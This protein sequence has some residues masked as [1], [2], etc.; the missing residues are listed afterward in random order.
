MKNFFPYLAAIASGLLLAMCYPGFEVASGLVWVWP[1]PLMAALWL[2]GG[3]SKRK[4][5][6]W[7]VG[8]VAGLVFWLINV[9]WLLAM[10]EL[11]T[12]PMVGALA[13]WLM[14]SIYLT[15]YFAIWGVFAATVGNPW[16]KKKARVLSVIEQKMAEKQE[17]AEQPKKRRITGF[18]ASMRVMRFAIMHASLWVV[19]EWLRGWVMTGFGWNGLGVAFHEVPVMMQVADIVGVSGVAFFPML[20][21]SVMLQTGKRFFDEVRAGKFQAHFEIG[22][23]MGIV[24]AVFAYGINRMAY[25]TNQPSH[26]VKVLILQENIPQTLKWDERLE[27]QH[28]IGYAE[29]LR[30]ELGEIAAANQSKMES[31]M[32][33]GEVVQLDYPDLLILPESGLTEPML[34]TGEIEEIYFLP[35][36][37]DFLEDQVF[38]EN[39]FKVIFGSTLVEGVWTEDGLTYHPEG[40]AFNA[41]AVAEPSE[42]QQAESRIRRVLTHGKNHLVPFG[43]YLPNIPFLAETAELFS[44]TSYAKNFSKGGSFDPLTVELQGEQIQLIPTVCFEDSVGRLTRKFA[45][46]KPQM[47]VNITNDGWFGESEAA[48]QHMANAKFRS[49]E[50][51]RPMARAANTGVSGV[52]SVI[53]SLNDS[54]SGARN[55]IGTAENPFI[56]GGLFTTVKVPRNGVMTIYA[57]FGDWF[58]ACC[59]LLLLGF[60]V[61][62]R[63][64]P[65]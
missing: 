15:F 43:E 48:L 10:G 60:A 33:S 9:K 50:L 11:D 54:G 2:G 13:G 28:Y 51:R 17:S 14:L 41:F 55:A 37:R 45:R 8:G 46:T 4:R 21:A 52:V 65:R 5:F 25:H 38:A 53:G 34:Y 31:A 30:T 35:L 26:D 59:L 56:K 63:Y 49:V 29:S 12:V 16:R 44:G 3:E 32:D 20:L 42:D 62:P 58:V 22:L 6:G 1:L 19:L 36:S 18:R 23:S 61:I 64:L 39:H 24:A 47:L 7:K 40:D 27:A 57:E